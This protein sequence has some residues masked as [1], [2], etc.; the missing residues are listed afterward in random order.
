MTAVTAFG[1][2]KVWRPNSTFF[3]LS[4][5]SETVENENGNSNGIIKNGIILVLESVLNKRT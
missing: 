5:L 1:G 4:V 3:S 2:R